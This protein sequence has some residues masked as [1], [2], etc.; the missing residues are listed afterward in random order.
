MTYVP[1]GPPS[2]LVR[3]PSNNSSRASARGGRA[4]NRPG[5]TAPGSL[6]SAPLP[7][8][9]L[10]HLYAWVDSVPFS[11]PKRHL[12]RD[13]SDGVMIAEIVKHFQ[14]KLVEMHNYIPT[15]NTE[16]KLSNWSTLN[17]QVFPKL[18]FYVSEEDIRRVVISTPGAIE[19]VLSTLRQKVEEKC[20][21]KA[22]QESRVNAKDPIGFDSI[23]INRHLAELENSKSADC[24]TSRV[25]SGK[26]VSSQKG[27]DRVSDYSGRQ[28]SGFGQCPHN[29]PNFQQLL[30]EKE[31]ALTMLQETVQI[32]QMKVH[33]LEHLVQLKDMRIEDLT[34]HLN[35][36]K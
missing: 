4:M 35:T 29:E 7:L 11:R 15:S 19:S 20:Q 31:Q 36:P 1:P 22:A 3:S 8:T 32:L 24:P 16:Q 12:A 34:R 28:D 2:S 18:R 25:P 17:R 23:N 13:F 26:K 21:K 5:R 27:E 14:P 30:E 10:H 9:A 6:L 33:R